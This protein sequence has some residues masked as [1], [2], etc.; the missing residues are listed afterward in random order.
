MK[1]TPMQ[2]NESGKVQ[3]GLLIAVTLAAGGAGVGSK[4]HAAVERRDFSGSGT[5]AT[6]QTAENGVL[7]LTLAASSPAQQYPFYT[8]SHHRLF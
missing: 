4:L 1:N 2:R 3:I 7:T 8:L 6:F 5:H